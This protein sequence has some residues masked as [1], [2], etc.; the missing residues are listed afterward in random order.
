VHITKAEMEK[1]GFDSK[2]LQEVVPKWVR[3]EKRMAYI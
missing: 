3:G 1:L 2:F